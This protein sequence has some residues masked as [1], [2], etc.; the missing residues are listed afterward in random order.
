MGEEVKEQ[1]TVSPLEILALVAG[2]DQGERIEWLA[3]H[4]LAHTR[5]RYYG[6][7][8][9]KARMEGYDRIIESMLPEIPL[10]IA[11]NV[12]EYHIQ[13]V[14]RQRAAERRRGWTGGR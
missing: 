3:Q 1:T 11:R 13:R 5:P 6:S 2:K 12:V 10:M 8:N 4:I 9:A 7:V 14:C